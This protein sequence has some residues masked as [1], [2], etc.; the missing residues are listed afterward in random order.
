M[1]ELDYDFT[2]MPGGETV[3]IDNQ[4]EKM[5]SKSE[6]ISV[7]DRLPELRV[8]VLVFMEYGKIDVCW[9]N[10]NLWFQSIR[11]Q[12]TNGGVSHWMPLP[13]PPTK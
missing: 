2:I 10:G 4:L 1:T 13:D 12:H 6:W 8:P 7:K 5:C 9:L 11:P 3:V